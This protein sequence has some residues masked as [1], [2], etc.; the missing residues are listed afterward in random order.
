MKRQSKAERRRLFV[1]RLRE[2]AAGNTIETW[3]GEMDLARQALE[4]IEPSANSAV[5]RSR[6][7]VRKI[8]CPAC[9]AAIGER[10][11]GVRGRPRETNH[12]E[13]VELYLGTGRR[14]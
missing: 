12:M 7:R 14:R 10:C 1:A 4:F 8:A 3:G 13:R 11:R 5:L 2:T 6:S 9:G